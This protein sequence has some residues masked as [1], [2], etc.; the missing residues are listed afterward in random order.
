MTGMP[1]PEGEQ[2]TAVAREAAES[3]QVVYLTDH[4]RRLVAIVSAGLA[5]LLER[6]GEGGSRR[7]LGARA[8]GHSGRYD[9]SERSAPCL[10]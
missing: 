7:V 9:I 1:L 2:L 5:K 4:G 10:R 6:R 8:A 3:G